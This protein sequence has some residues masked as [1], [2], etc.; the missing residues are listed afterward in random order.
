M[1][2]Q[3]EKKNNEAENNW[4]NTKIRIINK[5]YGVLFGADGKKS[6][7]DHYVECNPDRDYGIKSEGAC[8]KSTFIIKKETDSEFY[9]IVQQKYGVMFASYGD[10]SD[11]DHYVQCSP[12]GMNHGKVRHLWKIKQKFDGS[13]VFWID[14]KEYGTLFVADSDKDGSDHLVE[15]GGNF[16]S[17]KATFSF[18]E[19]FN[20]KVLSCDFIIDRAETYESKPE[21]IDVAYVTNPSSSTAN[22]DFAQGGECSNT[23][24]FSHES[25]FELSIGME[26]SAG[27]P[28]VAEA[29]EEITMST[30][31]TFT[32][33]EETTR[34]K[35][36]TVNINPMVGP[37]GNVKVT[38]SVW[39]KR[40]NVPYVMKIQTFDGIKESRGVY[41][42][43]D[44]LSVIYKQEDVDDIPDNYNA[45]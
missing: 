9:Q 40:F 31:T 1:A 36:W 14:N 27:V 32:W 13:N 38:S 11:D 8:K 41:K 33:G 23:S 21:V 39:K 10:K 34:T 5:K 3:D 28:L 24:S 12:D 4:L 43:V 26:F 44:S 29:K 22:M 6:D 35:S 19:A 20:V 17:D 45:Q 2:Q 15:C 7:V 18:V 42:G 37:K 25:G 16:K 30:H